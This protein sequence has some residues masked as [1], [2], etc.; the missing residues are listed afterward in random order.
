MIQARHICLFLSLTY[1]SCVSCVTS[2]ETLFQISSKQNEHEA[3][4]CLQNG[5]KNC[6]YV[7][8]NFGALSP[9]HNTIIHVPEIGILE[10]EYTDNY[11]GIMHLNYE[12]ENQ[13][14]AYL[15]YLASEETLIGTFT[16]VTGEIRKLAKC[17]DSCYVFYTVVEKTWTD[18]IEDSRDSDSKQNRKRTKKELKIANEKLKLRIEEC[19]KSL[20]EKQNKSANCAWK[21]CDEQDRNVETLQTLLKN[22]TSENDMLKQRISSLETSL[23]D[24]TTEHDN[25]KQSRVEDRNTI[26]A[27]NNEIE[28]LDNLLIDMKIKNEE[29]EKDKID[30]EIKE[31]ELMTIRE[32]LSNLKQK[33][34][35]TQDV[36]RNV[37]GIPHTESDLS[38]VE[39]NVVSTG[40]L[41]SFL[42]ITRSM[43]VIFQG[44]G[45]IK[46]GVFLVGGGG[47]GHDYGGGGSGYL[48]FVNVNAVSEGSLTLG[49]QIGNGGKDNEAGTSTIVSIQGFVPIIAKGGGPGTTSGGSGW[50]G[51]GATKGGVGGSNGSG[52]QNRE[53]W[54]GGRYHQV[55]GGKG[56][57]EALPQVAFGQVELH[58]GKG[59]VSQ[60]NWY[61]GGG[62]GV[63]VDGSAPKSKHNGVGDGFGGG[64]RKY[65]QA[66]NG[67]AILWIIEYK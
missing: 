67:V 66:N 17:G 42:V 38:V 28:H 44:K 19:E 55:T 50:S 65:H 48:E 62:G 24:I 21:N 15:T 18:E 22:M 39:Q 40:F 13:T 60:S 3:A 32:E 23:R 43:D 30:I 51:G 64:G 5:V 26:T 52:G 54:H 4:V 16:F 58:P 29:L 46:I 1:V 53:F 57:G 2:T 36:I 63:L 10:L 45:K 35:N 7:N 8:I 9:D 27:K 47:G 12:N 33:Y 49:V 11:D 6:T 14:T 37:E 20:D 25:V 56:T 61:G 34:A 59:G 41:N 31:K